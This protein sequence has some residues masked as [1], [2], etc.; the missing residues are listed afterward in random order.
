MVGR[1][2]R[3]SKQLCSDER[4][5]GRCRTWLRS[6]CVTIS[7]SLVEGP[8]RSSIRR[9]RAL[10]QMTLLTEPYDDQRR[11]WP[12]HGRHILAQFTDEHIVLYQAYRPEIASYAVIHQRFGGAFSFS[13]MSWIKPNFLWMMYRSGWG[14]KAGREVTLALY[15]SR[16]AFDAI[17]RQAVPS[18][19]QPD[20]YS[21]NEAWSEA[22][23][24][25]DVRLQWDPDHD[26]GGAPLSRRAVQLGLRGL[27][28]RSFATDWLLGIE[29]ISE[30]VAE[31]S[32][33]LGTQPEAL[34]T[35]SER[36]LPLPADIASR[37]GV[38]S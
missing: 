18:T 26:P 29:D 17:L 30:F 7:A 2:I 20:L 14:S 35:P 25:S 12:A 34:V 9:T 6:E 10:I 21:S 13:R 23:S 31:Q 22:V 24:A 8:K 27:A 38:G 33:T 1:R 16:S 32:R 11:V 28:L 19:F 3:R 15:L 4:R 5:N 37:L 36:A